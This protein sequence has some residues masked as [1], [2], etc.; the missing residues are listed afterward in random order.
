MTEFAHST[1]VYHWT[2]DFDNATNVGSDEG[3][4]GE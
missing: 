1:G 2:N 4:D 3:W